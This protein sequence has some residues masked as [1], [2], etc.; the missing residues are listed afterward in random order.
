MTIEQA[1]NPGKM[2]PAEFYR[3]LGATPVWST[4][5]VDSYNN[6]LEKLMTCLRAGDFMEQIL[7]RDVG[8]ETWEINR[9]KRQQRLMVEGNFRKRIEY[10]AKKAREVNDRREALR[11]TLAEKDVNSAS[12]AKQ[13]L[14]LIN[15]IEETPADVDALL[16]RN[17]DEFDHARAL[18]EGFDYYERLGRAIDIAIARRNDALE[19]LERYREGLGQQ[20]RKLSNQIIE[21]VFL[22][23]PQSGHVEAPPVAPGG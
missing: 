14:E 18:E 11:R 7:I 8:V 21:E 12:P 10:Q 13:A 15:F 22:E 2:D 23:A 3:V 5:N 4:E 16:H 9:L 6:I 1:K 17:A 19:Q 20:V